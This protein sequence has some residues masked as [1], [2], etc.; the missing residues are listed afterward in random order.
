MTPL[1]TLDN[2][3]VRQRDRWLL[4][5]LSWCINPGEQWVLNGPNGAG[6]TTLAKAIAGLLPVVQGKIRY[7]GFDG[8]SPSEAIAYMASDARRD[9]WRRERLLDQGRHFAGRFDAATGVR[10]WLA[11]A[12]AGPGRSSAAPPPLTTIVRQVGM[13]H[14]LDKPL[15]ALSTGEMGRVLIARQLLRGPRM[16]ILDEPFEGLDRTARR[17]MVTMLD[18]LAAGGLCLLLITHRM[19][20]RL[21]ATSHV[22]TLDEGRIVS[23]GAAAS[24]LS[25]RPTAS[26]PAARDVGRQWDCPVAPQPATAP[27]LVEMQDVTVRYGETIVLD[28]ISWT[29]G[30]NEHWAVTGPNGAGKSTLLKLITGECLQVYA[31]RIRLFGHERGAA[32]TLD[33]IRQRLGVVSPDLAT[34][35]QKA[36]NA[37]EVVCSGFFDSVGL[38]RRTDA[39]QQRRARQW[40]DR[41]GASDLAA[42]PFNH[43]SQGQRQLVLIARAM[44]KE[45][46]LL[47]LDEPCAGLDAGHRRRVVALLERIG[48]ESGTGLVHVSHHRREIPSCTTHHLMLASGR[49]VYCGPF[50]GR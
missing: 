26:D 46:R 1:V 34:A 4:Q 3:A 8:R 5:G 21:S 41:V 45:P 18:A 9:L 24:L 42:T 23:A 36:V 37:L 12:A 25:P 10:E 6:K 39:H 7:P 31:N 22:L 30:D 15:E 44:V 32:Q 16:L 48:R 50:D 27:A 14:L 33:A 11:T 43:L 40:L 49:S 20:E 19:E 35:Y 13:Q 38:Y 17:A 29:V 2:I 47:I 28:R